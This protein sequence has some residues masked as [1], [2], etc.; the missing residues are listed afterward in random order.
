MQNNKKSKSYEE[1]THPVLP[2]STVPLAV[3]VEARFTAKCTHT[4]EMKYDSLSDHTKHVPLTKNLSLRNEH[5]VGFACRWFFLHIH[6]LHCEKR[7]YEEHTH[8]TPSF[9]H[10]KF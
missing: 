4:K 3:L 8:H 9:A 7:P 1:I 6:T 10:S 2:C 5:A